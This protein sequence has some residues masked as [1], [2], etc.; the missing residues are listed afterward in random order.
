MRVVGDDAHVVERR[1]QEGEVRLDV[2]LDALDLPARRVAELA[3]AESP[4]VL[5]IVAERD[6]GEQRHDLRVDF[7]RQHRRQ[8]R[9]ARELLR[10]AADVLLEQGHRDQPGAAEIFLERQV[11][12]GRA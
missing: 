12:V 7:R 1:G 3:D 10:E 11:V 5:H 8:R 9:F 4:A 6:V 2:H